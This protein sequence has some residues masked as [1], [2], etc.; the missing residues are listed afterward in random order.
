[1]KTS[2]AELSPRR[3]AVLNRTAVEEQAQERVGDFTSECM[4]EPCPKP[5]THPLPAVKRRV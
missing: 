4:A 3:F 1:M 2:V 5:T